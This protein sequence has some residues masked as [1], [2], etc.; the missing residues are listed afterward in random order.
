MFNTGKGKFSSRLF[1]SR[2]SRIN[3]EVSIW[4]D[5]LRGHVKCS[6]L[7]KI[8]FINFLFSCGQWNDVFF[9]NK[10]LLVILLFS[11]FLWFYRTFFLLKKM[12]RDSNINHASQKAKDFF[13]IWKNIFPFILFV[14]CYAN[15][16]VHHTK[17]HENVYC[18]IILEYSANN[19][20]K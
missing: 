16:K 20:K 15:N 3:Y 18:C 19:T 2:I 9:V 10:T 11:K 13:S 17:M 1:F 6:L 5:W 14:G 12:R 7:K 8:A 4:I